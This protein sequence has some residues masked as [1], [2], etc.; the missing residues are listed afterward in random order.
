MPSR[1]N[2]YDAVFDCSNRCTC[3]NWCRFSKDIK[4]WGCRFL[5]I[6]PD[7]IPKTKKERGLLFSKAYAQAEKS[8]VLK[9]PHFNEAIIDEVVEDNDTL[10]MMMKVC[11]PTIILD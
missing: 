11:S 9:C 2:D 6:V 1:Y 8:G 10:E 7:R 3:E 5:I 4:G